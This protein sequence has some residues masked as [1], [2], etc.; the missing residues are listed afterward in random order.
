MNK[1]LQKI[2]GEIPETY[3]LVNHILTL[4]TDVIVRKRMAY[5]AAKDGGQRW[6]DVCSGTGE[7]AVNLSR[8]AK[9]GTRIFAADF[10]APMLKVAA[11]KP[12][13]KNIRFVLADVGQLPFPDNS[14][15]LITLSFATRNINTS[16]DNLIKTVTEFRRVLRPG[17]RYINLETSQPR[18]KFVKKLMHL[19]VRLAVKPIGSRISGSKAGYAYLSETI[20]RFYSAEEFA[21]ILKIAG[22]SEVT[23]KRMFFGIAALHKA[24]K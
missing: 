19:Y 24:V 22:Y 5:R 7:T 3:E 15:D 1:G 20:P 2:F 17:G 16:R 12:G 21:E 8:L 18:F 23:H 14:F 10:S 13:A 4:G 11:A 6:L 9:N